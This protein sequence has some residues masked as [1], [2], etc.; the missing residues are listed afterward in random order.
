MK[1]YQIEL[2]R[3]RD[4]THGHGMLRLRFDAG[5]STLASAGGEASASELSL[6]EADARTLQL[7]LKAQFA[8]IDARKARS[9]R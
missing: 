1:T 7:L 4:M 9:Q 6:S 3:I 2:L 8:Q 5:V